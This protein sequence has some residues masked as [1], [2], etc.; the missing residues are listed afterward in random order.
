VSDFGF[1]LSLNGDIDISSSGL[2]A[3]DASSAEGLISFE[4]GGA[5]SI[6]TWFEDETSSVSEV[7]SD[8]YNQLVASQPDLTFALISESTMAVD[9]VT[10]EYFTYVITNSAGESQ[11]GGISSAWKC[12]SS[13]ASSLT[14]TG[15]DAAVLQI[16]FKRILD[17]FSCS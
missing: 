5:K 9:S 1:T 3:A 12:S 6:L 17:G 8:T 11:G 7:L 4:Y 14:V 2:S 10:A 16:R 15:S 13:Q